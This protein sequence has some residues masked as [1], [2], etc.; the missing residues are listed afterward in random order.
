[1]EAEIKGVRSKELG[2]IL[3]TR[4]CWFQGN[5]LDRKSVV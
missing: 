3:R 2:V 1:M 5:T 4:F